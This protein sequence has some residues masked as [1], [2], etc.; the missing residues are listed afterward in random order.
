MHFTDTHAHYDDIAFDE[1]RDSVLLSLK[2]SGIGNVVDCAQDIKT[3][4]NIISLAK[5]YSFIYSAVGI[6][7]EQAGEAADDDYSE[8]EALTLPSETA[9]GK[10]VAIGETGL[11][12]HYEEYVPREIQKR[13]FIYNIEI[14]LRNGLP[15]VV[16]DREAHEDC[17]GILKKC[18]AFGKVPVVFHCFS[19]SPEFASRL[20][21]EGCYFSFG[22]VITFKNAKKSVEAVRIIP[23]D[24]LMLETD[25]P[26]LSPE[27]FRGRR[28]SSANI[29]LIAGKMAEILGKSIEETAEIT[30]RNA[31][32]FFGFSKFR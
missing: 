16:H 30:N 17:Y 10:I 24:R 2:D 14:A 15:I 1:D 12:Y 22:G 19:G 25:C 21:D 31:E 5:K 9:Q 11:D 27:P 8:L 6:H 32:A 29:P 4:K 20:S 23:E 28:N 7:P 26:Y 18:G 13:N 3:G